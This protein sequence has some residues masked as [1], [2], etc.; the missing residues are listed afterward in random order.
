MRLNISQAKTFADNRVRWYY[1]YVLK[2]VPKAPAGV[3]LAVGTATHLFFEYLEREGATH[4]LARA[5]AFISEEQQRLARENQ[6]QAAIKLL[7]EWAVLEAILP[8]WTD[9]FEFQTISLEEEIEKPLPSGKHTLYGRPDRLAMYGGHRWHVQNRTLAA[10]KPI[11]IYL[12]AAVLDPHE[13][14]YSYLADTYGTLFNIIRKLTLTGKTG[15]MLHRPSEC[16]VQEFVPISPGLVEQNLRGLEQIADE[17]QAIIDG[18]RPRP[19]LCSDSCRLGA[20]GNSLC[21]YFAVCAQQADIHD[22]ALFQDAV[23]P[24]EARATE[25]AE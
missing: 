20:Y 5:S 23:D 4:A 7:E 2:R 9:R 10:T 6:A 16:F 1:Q 22:P 18:T 14:G 3:A 17:M 11:A 19:Y 8:H 12:K 13:L 24:Y 15:K 25:V 21:P